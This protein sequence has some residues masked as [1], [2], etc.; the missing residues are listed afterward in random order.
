MHRLTGHRVDGQDTDEL[1]ILVARWTQRALHEGVEQ[2]IAG[3][4]GHA[5]KAAIGLAI[6]IDGRQQESGETS[7]IAAAGGVIT[8]I[9]DR[10]AGNEALDQIARGG[11][12]QCHLGPVLIGDGKYRIAAIEIRQG[13][14]INRFSVEAEGIPAD[15]L[16]HV[17]LVGISGDAVAGRLEREGVIVFTGELANAG[18]RAETA[19]AVGHLE[20]CGTNDCDDASSGLGEAVDRGSEVGIIEDL[21]ALVGIAGVVIGTIAD[22]G[23]LGTAVADGEVNLVSALL[24]LIPESGEAT[25]GHFTGL[26][27]SVAVEV[28][29]GTDVRKFEGIVGSHRSAPTPVLDAQAPE[30]RDLSGSEIHLS[31]R[32]VLLQ[33]HVGPVTDDPDCF[34][35]KVLSCRGA[36]GSLAES[37]TQ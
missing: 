33:R 23:S 32:V 2:A 18:G 30:V 16:I 37:N 35:L 15:L 25:S 14:V 12:E 1:F 17:V 8:S 29:T 34:G 6:A 5:L 36:W 22:A 21:L 27:C 31:D 26:S 20:A 24:A 19:V 13:E 28:W 9:V 3:I 4:E 11:I 10:V 7:Y